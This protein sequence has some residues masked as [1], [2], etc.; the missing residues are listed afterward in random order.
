MHKADVQ[1]RFTAVGELKQI[2]IHGY[3]LKFSFIK[4]IVI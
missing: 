1:K 4:I 3:H 2:D